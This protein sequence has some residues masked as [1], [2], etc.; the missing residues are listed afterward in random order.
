MA[1]MTTPAWVPRK[2]RGAEFFL[3]VLAVFIG[4]AAYA[5]VGLG[6]EGR[7]PADTY[8]LGGALILL[9]VATHVIVRRVAPYA[10]PVL[11]P[12]VIA[13]NGLGL[14]MI[15]RIDL[16]CAPGG[17]GNYAA[18]ANAQLMWTAIGIVSF[19]TILVL[20]RDHRR[21]QTLTYTFGAATIG[22]LILPLIP[23]LGRTINGSRIWIGLGPFSFQPGEAAKV[24]LAI[25]F[26]GYLVVKR[27]A[28]ALAGRRFLGIDLPRGRDL[29]PILAGWL[30]S[31]GILVFQ[32]DLGSSLLFFGL[33]VVM[34]YV[35]TERPGW[36]IVGAVLFAAGSY[37]GY[38]SFGHVRVRFDAWLDPFNDPGA[39]QIVTGLFGLAHGGVLGKGLGQGSPQ[40]TPFS[41]SDFIASSMGEE[42]GL[43]GLMAIIVIY[44]LIVE[45]GMRIALTCRD[46]FGK[47]LAVGL[48][49]SFALQV[50]VVIGGVTR[51][52]PL[53]GL[54]TPFMAQGG[55]SV[56]MNWAIVGLLLRI[57]DQTRRPAPEISTF[58]SNEETQVVKLS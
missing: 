36:L 52:I 8:K 12:L 46:A 27:D 26:A 16:A 4:I 53:T 48:A 20:V 50:F 1:S 17:C 9:A 2:R 25:F 37:F 51:L 41:F 7:I 3:T 22:L 42:L 18:H 6:A 21:L 39:Y 28:L 14:A 49:F 11:L 58:D 10:D 40:L 55:S 31:V 57:S 44:G 32:K 34:L 29:G 23:G 19:A 47:L 38:L 24:C 35:A 45:R 43:T 5:S 15:Y 33:F 30:I 13:L 56:V 54:T